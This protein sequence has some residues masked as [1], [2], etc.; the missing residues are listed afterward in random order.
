MKNILCFFTLFLLFALVSASDGYHRCLNIDVLHYEFAITINDTTDAISGRAVIELK[1][2]EKT[3]SVGFDLKGLNS[4]GMGMN[5]TGVSMFGKFIKWKQ[6]KESLMVLL[7]N[8]ASSDDTLELI[9]EYHGI[10]ADGLIISRNKYGDRTFFADH[11]PDRASK[12]LPCIDHP[13]DKATVDFLITAPE[14]YS[15][16]ANGTMIEESDIE[17]NMKLTHW[18]ENVP[19]PVKVM[20]FGVARFAVRYEGEVDNIPVWSWVF[21]QNRMEGFHDYSIALK[22]LE[23]YSR[24]IGHYPFEKL[25]MFS[26]RLFMVVLKMQEQFSMLKNR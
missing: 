24:V 15:V 17:N 25:A 9:I 4:Q 8:T 3:D 6:G 5:V 21:P 19:I 20:A 11:W 23:Y 12:Y 22:P 18:K 10:P 7:D 16:V 2:L 13:Y 14:R 1:I 26:Q